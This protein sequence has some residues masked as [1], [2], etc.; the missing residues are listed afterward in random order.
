VGH[1]CS[2]VLGDREWTQPGRGVAACDARVLRLHTARAGGCTSARLCRDQGKGMGASSH[3]YVDDHGKSSCADG[4]SK[5]SLCEWGREPCPY[6]E[7]ADVENVQIA[8]FTA[9]ET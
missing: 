1:V 5:M 3:Q 9:I 7:R 8:A 6:I 4:A 2:R